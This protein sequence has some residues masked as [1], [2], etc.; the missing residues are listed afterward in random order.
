MLMYSHLGETV[1]WLFLMQP[2]VNLQSEGL[3][4]KEIALRASE[5]YL[6]KV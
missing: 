2:N 5:N 4:W 6:K 1:Y 3:E